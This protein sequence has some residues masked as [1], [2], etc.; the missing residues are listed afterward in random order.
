MIFSFKRACV[1]L[2]LALYVTGCAVNPV[3]GQREITLVSTAQEVSI[4]EQ[5]YGPGR[6]MYGGDYVADPGVARYVNDVGARL[7]AVSDRSLPYEFVVIN[8]STPNAWALPGG[9]IAVHR[10]LLTELD[11]EAEL[12]AVLG[13]EIVHAAAR[14][15]AKSMQRGMVLQGALVAAS[16]TADDSPY[17]SLLMT[18]AGL[19]LQL[20][21]QKYGRD[22][23]RESDRYGML[24]MSRA[25]YDPAAAVT[26]Q[27]TFLR[28]AEG[29]QGGW[30]DGLF[31]SHPP[32][33]ERVTNNRAMLAELVAGGELG[34]E[35]YRRA[36][37][38]LLATRDAYAA[39]DRG[40]KALA[41]GDTATALSAAKEALADEPNEALFHVLRGDVR[42]AQSRWDD[43]LT[44]YQRGV[45]HNPDYFYPLMRR[46]LAH[47]QVG[48][49]R[50]AVADLE[51]SIELL[52][53]APAMNALGELK[54]AG[55]ER[56][57]AMELFR[58]AAQSDSP[59]GRSAAES[60]ARLEL[61]EK[62][63]R[64]LQTRLGQ[65]AAGQIIVEISNP[66]TLSVNVSELTLEYLLPDGRVQSTSQPISGR[67][68][69]GGVARLT[70]SISV[71][72]PRRLRAAV[73]RAE[74]VD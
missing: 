38:Q 27:E 1:S 30:L 70:L 33:A 36:M 73:T 7:A 45:K 69:P 60:L 34:T 48:N 22:A 2:V 44:N 50:L 68:D 19:S 71:D 61:P 56:A 16:V 9:K 49:T 15:G 21:N 53:N 67:L 10:G 63:Y 11:S 55:G 72:D 6:Q 26:L 4:G 57:A 18:G 74:L 17:G 14:H 41:E 20:L 8:D 58:A 40:R 64:Y 24:Y 47:R 54:L 25:G 51:R 62:P 65:D 43:A 5:Q 3:T 52:P 35:A 39:H 28:L 23:E 32:S 37:R 42:A 59:D 31:R 46:G 66:T 29:Q 12:A 13:H